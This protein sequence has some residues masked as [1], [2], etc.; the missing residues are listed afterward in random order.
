MLYSCFM[1]CFLQDVEL[2]FSPAASCPCIL[3]K[4][5][6]LIFAEVAVLLM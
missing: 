5:A 2:L 6:A 4:L 3:S 1:L